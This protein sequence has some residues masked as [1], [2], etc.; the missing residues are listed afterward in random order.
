VEEAMMRR[1]V[2]QARVGR[3]A[4]VGPGSLPHV[5][6]VCFVLD[7]ERVIT[8]VDRKPKTTT[9]LR[10]VTNVRAHPFASLLVDQ[11]DEDWDQ[12]W[13]IRLDGVARVID[14]GDEYD[15][16]IPP[17]YDKYRGQYGLHAPGGPA[18]VL[19]IERWSGWSAR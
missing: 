8:A 10:R 3:F 16:V 14:P 12:L 4:T 18:I 11:Y 19:D 17:L 15:D 5:V 2:V 13:W 9:E 7:G 1:R 6:P